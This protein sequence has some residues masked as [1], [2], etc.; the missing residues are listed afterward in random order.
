MPKGP[1]RRAVAFGGSNMV[2]FKNAKDQDAAKAVIKDRTSPSWSLATDLR[3][4]E[5]R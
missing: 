5:P 1:V 3:M 4:L 2:I